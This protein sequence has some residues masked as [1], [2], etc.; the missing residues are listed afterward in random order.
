MKKRKQRLQASPEK[1]SNILRTLIDNLP[2]GIF[3]KDRESR[4]IFANQ[5]LADLMGAP[6][7]SALQGK[8]DHDFYSKKVADAFLADERIIIKSRK[9]LVNREESRSPSGMVRL[10]T[11]KVPV[12]D[13]HGEV[14]GLLGI[15][16]NITER[17]EA[18]KT[19]H[20]SEQRY[21]DLLE[22]AAD[23]IYL[24]D[25]NGDFLLANPEICKMLGYTQEELLELNIFDTY[26]EEQ[27]EAAKARNDQIKSGQ[28][29][30]FERT[31]KRK[32]GSVLTAEVTAKRLV[33][34]T[35]HSI[36]RDI[37]ERKRTE[38]ELY[39]E[40]AFLTALMDN[41]PDTI[42]FKDRESR[43]IL[44]NS[45]HARV[46]GAGNPSEM[47]G[48]TDFDYF[49]PEHAQKAFNDEQSIIRT[50][51]PLLNDLE[52]GLPGEWVSTTKMPL[53]D[54]KGEIIGTFGVSRDMTERRQMEEK[55]LR[56]ATLV[57]SADDA[58]VGLDLNRRITVW[59]KG[60]ERL[61]G[62]SEQEMIGAPTSM[63]IPPDLEEEAQVIREKIKRGEQVTHFEATR[64]RKD[65][66]KV[67]VSLTLS[68]IRNTDGEI[69]GFASTA[70]DI[71]AQK[72]LEAQLSRIQRLESLATL[73]GGVAHQFNNINMV[74]RGNLELMR[75]YAGLPARLTS[76]VE[77][78]FAGVQRAV[79]ITDRLLALTQPPDSPSNVVQLD[80]LARVVISLFEKRIE[81]GEIQLV[82][83]LDATAPAQGDEGHLK[84]VLSS[85]IDN[86]LD[87]LLDRPVRMI[88]VRT[89]STQDFAYFEVE[90]SGCGI[91]EEDMPKI[92]S[93]FFTMKGE[94]APPSSPQA[95]VK[96]VGL[97]LAI[98]TTMLTEYGGRIEV[99]STKG[100]GSTFRIVLPLAP[101]DVSRKAL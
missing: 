57:N 42:Y 24:L 44:N 32:D 19:L 76:Y 46:L 69:V 34:G 63:L 86:A 3:L 39:R 51:K 80:A 92:F 17:H 101:V 6:D 79:A 58:I 65:G 70:R 10:L 78:A 91:S 41:I 96:G 77:A 75:S 53:L 9:R 22:Q 35:Q 15:T 4:F 11:T 23:G 33:D 85:I 45:A 74:I 40:R 56:L 31:M 7:P 71:T 12:L 72:A 27:R 37:T 66:S 26:P 47:L 60:A 95:K 13:V 88:N 64:L 52:Q 61:Y 93:P 25:G 14:T 84:F 62:Y 83:S 38:Q 2:D 67:I 1:N 16:R 28:K 55:N 94:W 29:L 30:L 68:A 5:V 8:T 82:L 98:S 54:E 97:S 49:A 59:N 50:G 87:S 100:V 43:F 89:S 90:D 73:A 21:R 48:K 36:A 99:Q 20:R 81:E 18:E